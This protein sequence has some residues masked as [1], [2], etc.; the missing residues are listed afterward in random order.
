[1]R[2]YGSLALKAHY[3]SLRKH[4]VI[5]IFF[6]IFSFAGLCEESNKTCKHDLYREQA[7]H[8]D[9]I[10]ENFIDSYQNNTYK[11]TMGLRYMTE[12][13]DS[14]SNFTFFIDGDYALNITNLLKYLYNLKSHK[15]FYGGQMW[16]GPPFRQRFHKHYRSLDQY[17]FEYYPPF[18]AAGAMLLSEDVAKR[19]FILSHYTEYFPFDDVYFGFIAKKLDVTAVQMS[20]LLPSTLNI[21]ERHARRNLEL[22]GSHRFGKL[23]EV[24]FIY[25]MAPLL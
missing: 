16:F 9:L 23:D 25:E 17:P 13:C 19:F 18:I 5:L 8:N 11:M 1:M 15:N 12:M 21:P 14:G 22:I 20:D 24:R 7:I 6:L 4:L 2:V 3:F 10:Q